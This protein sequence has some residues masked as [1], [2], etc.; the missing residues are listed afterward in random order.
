[1]HATINVTYIRSVQRGTIDVIHVKIYLVTL[2]VFTPFV[3]V[4]PNYTCLMLDL[5]FF[6]VLTYFAISSPTPTTSICVLTAVCCVSH[7][8]C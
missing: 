4:W 2:S 6:L 5:S 3:R 8:S 7:R 1:M